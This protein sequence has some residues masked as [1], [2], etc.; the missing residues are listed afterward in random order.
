MSDAFAAFV[1]ETR[2]AFTAINANLDNIVADEQTLSAQITSLQAQ[3]SAGLSVEDAAALAL[4]VDSAKALANRTKT[5]ADSVPDL[6][7]PPSV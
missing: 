3:I 6:P 7:P 2:T 4:V 1:A 5:V